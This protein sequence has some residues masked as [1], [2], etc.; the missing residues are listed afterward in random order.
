MNHTPATDA[1]IEWREQ[2][3][4]KLMLT[5]PC[6]HQG[7]DFGD[8]AFCGTCFDAVQQIGAV[9]EAQAAHAWDQGRA[10]ERRDWEL[11]ADLVTPDEDRRPMENPYRALPPVK[12]AAPPHTPTHNEAAT[13][14]EQ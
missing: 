1:L 4:V 3:G 7:E 6:G 5:M 12:P 14:E 10:A 13:S 8:G 9:I 2:V 11:T